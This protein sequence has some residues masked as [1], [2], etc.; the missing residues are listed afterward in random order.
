MNILDLRNIKVK[1]LFR[2]IDNEALSVVG[3]FYSYLAPKFQASQFPI[4]WCMWG[5]LLSF[6]FFPV[7]GAGGG[8]RDGRTANYPDNNIL[9]CYDISPDLTER[10]VWIWEGFTINALLVSNSL[11]VNCSLIVLF[12]VKWVPDCWHLHR[13]SAALHW[14]SLET[15][16]VNLNMA[17]GN[18]I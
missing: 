14:I 2:W 3:L 17:L 18:L 8:V 16:K 13:C 9:W 5:L 7:W 12:A 10:A 4:L 11:C 6:C 15:F 1:F